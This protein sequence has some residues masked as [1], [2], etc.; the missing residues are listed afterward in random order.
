MSSQNFDRQQSKAIR[1]REC[2]TQNYMWS[3]KITFFMPTYKCTSDIFSY[4][5]KPFASF[6]HHL[7][8]FFL[9]NYSWASYMA[10]IFWRRNPTVILHS[11]DQ[12]RPQ[13][14][15]SKT[16]SLFLGI[17]WTFFFA[18]LVMVQ[19]HLFLWFPQIFLLFLSFLIWLALEGEGALAPNQNW[20]CWIDECFKLKSSNKGLYIFLLRII[21]AQSCI[22][23]GVNC[24]PPHQGGFGGGWWVGPPV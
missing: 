3:A 18:Q 17:F 5:R 13:L 23:S 8:Q 19:F 11:Q 6:L 2:R 4:L 9:S 15:S 22:I 20:R 21:S 16:H 1:K 14:C 12:N 7:F 24:P 10:E